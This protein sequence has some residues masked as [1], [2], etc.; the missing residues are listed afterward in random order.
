[1]DL[2]LIQLSNQVREVRQSVSLPSIEVA[3]PDKGNNSYRLAAKVWEKMGEKLE[4]VAGY[5][6]ILLN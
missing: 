6:G 5:A 2:R 4:A 3:T 1:L